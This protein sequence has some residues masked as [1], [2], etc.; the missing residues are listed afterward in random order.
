VVVF[1]AIFLDIISEGF[2]SES[3]IALFIGN[4]NFLPAYPLSLVF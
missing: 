4:L 3:I 1:S 2:Q